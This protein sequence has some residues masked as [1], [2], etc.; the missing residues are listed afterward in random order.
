MGTLMVAI[1]LKSFLRPR[2]LAAIV[3]ACIIAALIIEGLVIRQLWHNTDQL[4]Q[5]Q[6]KSVL[7]DAIR[8]LNQPPA[9]EPTTGRQFLPAY[10]IVLPADAKLRLF[11]REG[12][13]VS[14]V[15]LTDAS[16]QAQAISKIWSGQDL[17]AT[18]SGVREAQVCS[19]LGVISFTDQ[20]SDAATPDD[21]LKLVIAKKLKDGRT[22]SIYQNSA[23]PYGSDELIT[24][25]KQVESF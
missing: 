15:W 22:A 16:K 19:R 1:N 2:Y 24:L 7:V 17:S 8:G 14:Y 6:V 20:S 10:H 23:C 18:F 4:G 21:K 9:V 11:Y 12:G 5:S 13:E 3:G 25:L